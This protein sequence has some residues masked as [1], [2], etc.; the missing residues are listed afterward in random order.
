VIDAFT[1]TMAGNNIYCFY[2]NSSSFSGTETISGNTFSNITGTGATNVYGY[3]G[4]VFT[5][6]GQEIIV[7]DNVISG[8]STSGT[9]ANA[10]MG[11]NIEKSNNDDDILIANNQ[12][13][14]LSGGA[15]IT[16][17]R[18]GV[19]TGGPSST[20]NNNVIHDLHATDGNVIGLDATNSYHFIDGNTIYNLSSTSSKSIYGIYLTGYVNL[21]CTTNK[22]V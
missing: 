6:G 8:L 5:V 18:G 22:I 15:A 20:F 16:G 14:N 10:V 1:K 13:Y 2:N 21:Y 3:Y 17:I 7:T 19:Q 4:V 12:V 9:A 11:I